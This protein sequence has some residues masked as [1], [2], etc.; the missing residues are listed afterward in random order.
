LESLRRH[1]D[2]EKMRHKWREEDERKARE[3]AAD[4]K[5]ERD[6]AWAKTDLNRKLLE[7]Q[8]DEARKELEKRE[9][10]RAYERELRENRWKI[11]HDRDLSVQLDLDRIL[12]KNR[13]EKTRLMQRNDFAPTNDYVS[14]NDFRDLEANS[15]FRDAFRAK[16]HTTSRLRRIKADEEVM[17]DL[18]RWY[19]NRDLDRSERHHHVIRQIYHS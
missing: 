14:R 6:N 10:Q 8:K 18:K 19:K 1:E 5:L 12:E 13:R 7:R 17:G 15:Q 16:N 2:Y 9:E 3:R 11:E 4:E